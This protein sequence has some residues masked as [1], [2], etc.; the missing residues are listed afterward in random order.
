MIFAACFAFAAGVCLNR[1]RW[2]WAAFHAFGAVGI[3]ILTV[4]FQ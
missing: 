1:R 4:A 2:A 3:A